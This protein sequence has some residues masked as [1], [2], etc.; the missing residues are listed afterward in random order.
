MC[1][2]YEI[3]IVRTLMWTLHYVG[4][5]FCGGHSQVVAIVTASRLRVLSLADY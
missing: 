2:W 4:D 5:G 1:V 3:L